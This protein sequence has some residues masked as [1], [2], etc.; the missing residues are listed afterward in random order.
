M[1]Y[2]WDMYM[3]IDKEIRTCPLYGTKEHHNCNI[4]KRKNVRPQARHS[5][6]T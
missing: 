1:G 2:L 3:K 6:I 4:N 5:L